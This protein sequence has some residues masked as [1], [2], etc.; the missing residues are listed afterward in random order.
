ML[1]LTIGHE[2]HDEPWVGD[3]GAAHLSAAHALTHFGH[4]ARHFVWGKGTTHLGRDLIP[5]VGLGSLMKVRWDPW[6]E[7]GLDD[8]IPKSWD[9]NGYEKQAPDPYTRKGLDGAQDSWSGR[10]CIHYPDKECG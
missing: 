10:G 6:W 8:H 9:C 5:G 7:V 2:L 1:A 4:H 3:V